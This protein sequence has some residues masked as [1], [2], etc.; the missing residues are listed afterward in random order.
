MNQFS[1][2]LQ[3]VFQTIILKIDNYFDSTFIEGMIK[4][5][6]EEEQF[7]TT[8]QSHSL[9]GKNGWHSSRD[10]SD[11]NTHLS[12]QLNEY[13]TNAVNIYL[14]NLGS[15]RKWTRKELDIKTW[16][17]V[18]RDNDWSFPHTHGNADLS[19]AFYLAVPNNM[20]DTEGNFVAI[21]PRGGAR[22]SKLLGSQI[23]RFKPEVGSL[24]MF[25][26]WLDHYVE[27]HSTGLRLSCG[28][29]VVLKD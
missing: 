16:A 7:K 21:D 1:A 5:I 2:V 9:L 27:P 28:W 23:V 10:L 24:L 25:P 17:M 18:M 14:T 15:N 8:T 19:G 4:L 20:S 29:N 26:G 12:N 3:P 11:R 22:G 6:L 13:I